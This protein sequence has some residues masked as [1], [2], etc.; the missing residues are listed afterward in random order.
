MQ[1]L[2]INSVRQFGVAGL[3]IN[4]AGFATI[5]Q[6]AVSVLNTPGSNNAAKAANLAFWGCHPVTKQPVVDQN[7]F[8]DAVALLSTPAGRDP[9]NKAGWLYPP[10]WQQLDI[11]FNTTDPSSAG[12]EMVGNPAATV[13]ALNSIGV[14]TL[15]VYW[16]SCTASTFIFQSVNMA[17]AIYWGERWELYKHQYILAG[18]AWQRGIT[19][20]EYWNE[21]RGTQKRAR[22]IIG[23]TT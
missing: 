11:N 19:R 16:L 15:M 12:A 21:V 20:S 18:W 7:S 13:K 1:H 6:M 10:A 23:S 2:G 9:F 17:D 5:Q 3:G 8:N 22:C 4:G 14:S